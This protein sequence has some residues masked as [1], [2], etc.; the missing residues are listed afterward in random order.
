MRQIIEKDYSI[1]WPLFPHFPCIMLDK[2]KILR[3]CSF[4]V[5]WK[6]N[7]ATMV[8]ILDS[9][10]KSTLL[11]ILSHSSFCYVILVMSSI[12]LYETTAYRNSNILQW[13]IE[14]LILLPNRPIITLSAIQCLLE[15]AMW[16]TYASNHTYLPTLMKYRTEKCCSHKTWRN[17][18][19]FDHNNPHL[20]KSMLSPC[21]LMLV[22][23]FP[24]RVTNRLMKYIA[25]RGVK[26]SS[27]NLYA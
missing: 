7:V 25:K 1:N 16:K 20:L 2:K 8:D 5:N 3:F 4:P 27:R 26:L 18:C 24:W 23:K 9:F 14:M 6:T 10:K 12:T 17:H 13:T 22:L 21:K 19:V 11:V 15:G